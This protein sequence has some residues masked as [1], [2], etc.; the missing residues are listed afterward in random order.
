MNLSKQQK[1][2]L[3]ILHFLPIIGII[4]YIWFFFSFFF[5]NIQTLENHDPNVPP[6]EFL[7]SFFGAFMILI[8][9]M[10]IALGIKIFDIVHLVKSNKNDTG[11]KILIWILLLVFTGTIGEIVYYF[12]EILPEKKQELNG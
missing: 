5:N 9:T 1:I 11:N 10:I 7:S 12:I 3:G 2:L 6:T 4:A 8:I